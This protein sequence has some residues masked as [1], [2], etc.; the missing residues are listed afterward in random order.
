MV[1]DI[2]LPTSDL[3][4][5][6]ITL[7][8]LAHYGQLDKAGQP[9]ILHPIR[10]MMSLFTV[11]EKIVGILHDVAEDTNVTLDDLSRIFPTNIIVAVDALTH[12]LNESYEDYI[13]RIR[14][15]SKLAVRVKLA[16]L[17]DNMNKDRIPFPSE[18]DVRRWQKYERAY[19]VLTS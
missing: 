2:K 3:L 12:R 9:Y 1:N 13:I 6:A 4:G 14:D 8:I 5:K 16:D 18:R 11:E 17:R 19:A 7:A 10:V 15:T